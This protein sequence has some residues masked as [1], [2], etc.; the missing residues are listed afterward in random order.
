MKFRSNDMRKS[1]AQASSDVAL[2]KYWGKKDEVLRLPENGSISMILKGL[3]TMTTVE[4]REDSENS[5]T[6]NGEHDDAEAERVLK[7]IE[8]IKKIAV[9]KNVL[10]EEAAMKLRV[11]VASQNTFPKGTG[12]SSSGSGFAALTLAAV[13]ALEMNLSSKE[14]SILARQGS[15]TACRCVLGGFVEW[16]DGDTSESSY[17]VSLHNAGHWD[18]RDVVAVVDKG[19]KRISSTEGHESAR[20]SPFYEAR[21]QRIKKKLVDVKAVLAEK[22]FAQ[23]GELVEAE[24]LEFHSI[25]LTS[26]PS[27]IAWYPGTIEVM[28]AVQALRSEGILAYFTIN[29][30][31]NVHVLTL[32]E[33]EEA[34]KERLST[35][36]LVKETLT[37]SVGEA[38]RVIQDHLFQKTLCQQHQ[39]TLP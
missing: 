2:V 23:L 31:F 9:A 13:T 12:L 16:L 36:S 15:G 17:S 27:L 33:Y 37:A 5:V 8:R 10:S 32:P 35:L 34:V 7:H 19:K 24:A 4:F 38:P 20:S 39:S 14:L 11:N 3:D 26:Q 30:G 29:T 1:T 22:D 6:I 25:L 28:L 18:I 21:L